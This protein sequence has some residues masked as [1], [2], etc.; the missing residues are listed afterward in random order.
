MSRHRCPETAREQVTV[1]LR[2]IDVLDRQLPVIDRQLR[3]YAR[4]QV[5]CKALMGHYGIGELTAVAIL[6]ELGDCRRFSSS[7]Q[8]SATSAWTSPSISPISAARRGTSAAKAPPRCAGRCT[9]LPWSPAEQAHPSATTTSKPPPDSD[10][11]AR[12][13]RSPANSSNAATTRCENSARRPSSP[14][15]PSHRAPAPHISRCTAT[16]SRQTAAA[17]PAWTARKD[18]AAAPHFPQRESHPIT[19]MSPA[20]SQPGSW[21]KISMGARAHTNADSASRRRLSSA[22]RSALR[23]A[24]GDR[25]HRWRSITTTWPGMPRPRQQLLTM[26]GLDKGRL[27]R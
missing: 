18:R 17:T 19:I 26:R 2:M 11:N 6:A 16:S 10:T 4:R 21:T 12:A 3:A 7:R 24:P 15:E 13:W 22:P 25:R 23:A 5:G 1:A 20:R 9:R 8:P 14:H 27:H